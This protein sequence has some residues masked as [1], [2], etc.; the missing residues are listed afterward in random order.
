MRCQKCGG[1][2]WVGD[3]EGEVRCLN[4]AKRFYRKEDPMG[5]CEKNGCLSKTDGEFCVVHETDSV[6]FIPPTR[7]RG[8]WCRNRPT[9][10]TNACP[11]HEDAQAPSL[12]THKTQESLRSLKLIRRGLQM[13]LQR[14]A[15]LIRWIEAS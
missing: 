9:P 13:E 4:C 6:G 11:K 12:S 14:V 1:F 5:R 3:E 8:K 10:G 7:C 2:L 15:S